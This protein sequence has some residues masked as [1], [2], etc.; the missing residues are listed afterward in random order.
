[1]FFI[2][3]KNKMFKFKL[4]FFLMK[5]LNIVMRNQDDK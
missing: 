2:K 4:K 1:M 5:K 3:I